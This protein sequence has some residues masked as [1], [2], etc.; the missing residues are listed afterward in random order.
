MFLRLC[1]FVR[2]SKLRNIFNCQQ[3]RGRDHCLWSGRDRLELNTEIP[4]RRLAA[5]VT[6]LS[7][8]TIFV[9]VFLA[10]MGDVGAQPRVSAESGGVAVGGSVSGSTIN[11]GIPPEQL[12]TLVRQAADLSESQKKLIASLEGQLDL[13]QRQIGA[14]L[15]ILGEKDVPPERLAAK[16]VEIAERFKDLQTSALTQPGDD[17]RI[18]A[19]RADAQK[20]IDAGE[21]AK[22]DML[23]AAVETEQRRDLDRLAVNAADTSARRGQIA[24]TQLRYTEAAKRFAE[25]AAVFPL[26]SANEDKRIGYLER[27]AGALYQQGDEFGDNDSLRAAIERRKRLLDLRPQKAAPLDWAI[28]QNNLGLALWA[29]GERESGTARL[30]EAVVAFRA[31]LQERTRE[32]V[33]LAWATTQNDLGNALWA[34]GE[35]ESG[36][37]RLEEAVA[38]FRTAL[39]EQTRERAPLDWAMTQT[40]LGNAL[41]ALGD[42]ESGTARLEEAVAAYRAAL[43]EWTRERVPLEWAAT[44]NNLGVALE[45]LG[46]REGGT[47]R[48]EEAVAAFRTALQEWTRER[49]PLDWAMTQNDL[50]N[51][52]STLGRRESGTVRL[53]EAVTAYRAALEERTRERVPLDWAMTQ[54]NLG[55]ALSTLGDRESGTARLEEGVAAYRAALQER[56]RERVP[57]DWA[58]TQNNLGDALQALGDR[59]SGTARLDEAVGAY[60]AALQE[61]TLERVPLDWARSS[62][63][64][65]IALKILAERRG[66]RAMAEQ[67]LAQINFTVEIYREASDDRGKFYE[68]QLTGA[69]ALVERLRGR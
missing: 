62:G 29:L 49:V 12:A 46:G 40:N 5:I 15:N 13:N 35:R 33:P 48:L 25:A 32:R 27:E 28:T 17:P 67:A 30:E 23:L 64:Q 50:G 66:D 2:D 1:N 38:A 19:L 16:L 47:A 60:G 10:S 43:Q 3:G 44:H 20:A 69:R 4:A 45:A 9:L 18:A 54:N 22:A 41:Q 59:E 51:A 6:L 63:N 52:L 53:E 56:T 65:G 58:A 37:A 68:A 11:I 57:L 7:C 36:T 24:L 14:A 31:A 42:R 8:A 55:A 39:Q 61:W 21:L 26:G 34:L